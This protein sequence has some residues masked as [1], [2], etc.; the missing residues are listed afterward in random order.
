MATL[1]VHTGPLA[2]AVLESNHSSKSLAT[3]NSQDTEEDS[4]SLSSR[5]TLMSSVSARSTLRTQTRLPL[6]SRSHTN[7][8]KTNINSDPEATEVLG[9][10]RAVCTTDSN[11]SYEQADPD[12]KTLEP[13]TQEPKEMYDTVDPA[14]KDIVIRDGEVYR[15]LVS[16]TNNGTSTE[17]TRPHSV[18]TQLR[19][20]IQRR[21]LESGD[22]AQ[23]IAP[24]ALCTPFQNILAQATTK[25]SSQNPEP[26]IRLHTPSGTVE[27]RWMWL[28]TC[29]SSQTPLPW[30]R[31]VFII[32]LTPEMP[33]LTIS[34]DFYINIL[35]LLI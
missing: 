8:T 35:L 29:T 25:A 24:E 19:N 1:H 15:S 20:Q 31:S 7:M 9:R 26:C 5:A 22:G 16:M 32:L 17:Y 23:H 27:V 3:I 6:V 11:A 13:S 21:D 28:G 10:L 14:T 34:P 33:Q 18:N 30:N 4:L 2:T 12:Y